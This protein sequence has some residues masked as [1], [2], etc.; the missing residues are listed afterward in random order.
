MSIINK[1]ND[2]LY[3]NLNYYGTNPIILI[4]LI[5]IIMGYYIIYKFIG[6]ENKNIFILL[7]EFFI[8]TL[9]IILIFINGYYYFFNTN[10]ITELR[11]LAT[12]EPQLIIKDI[13]DTYNEYISDTISE[14]GST[15]DKEVYHIP[16]SRFTYHDAKAVCNAF[17][18]DLATY[19]QLKDA[20]KEGASWC[21]YGWTEDQLAL[22]PTSQNSWEKLQNDKEHKYDCGFPGINGNYIPNSYLKLGAN[23]Y[24]VKPKLSDI[25]IEA[26][27][28]NTS[29]KVIKNP[30]ELIFEE[31]VKYWKNRIG[32][33]LISP[34][35]NDNWY[36]I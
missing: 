36:K 10:I 22:Y 14:N 21:S 11:D 8:W 15:D 29:Q 6:N 28:M 5:F 9:L 16:G 12:D 23:C 17:D 30:K 27:E 31:R 33:I 26:L 24:G 32:N 3:D 34:F 25:D 13:K 2:N 1:I 35:N 4:A 19:E 7:F 20:Q 18:A